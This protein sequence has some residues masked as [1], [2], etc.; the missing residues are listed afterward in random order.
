[1]AGGG[2]AFSQTL[3]SQDETNMGSGEPVIR[4]GTGGRITHGVRRFDIGGEST[5][6]VIS[7]AD[8]GS[9]YGP[10]DFGGGFGGNG[11]AYDLGINPETGAVKFDFT[12]MAPPDYGPA[13][14][15][16]TYCKSFG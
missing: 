7:N 16:R 9:D 13:S 12:G 8:Y 10:G 6:G 14:R 3:Q 15:F 5:L 1:M 4:Y 11:G 2:A